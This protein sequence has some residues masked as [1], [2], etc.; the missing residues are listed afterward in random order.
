MAFSDYS[1]AFEYWVTRLG[2]SDN[3]VKRFKEMEESTLFT[4]GQ[5]VDGRLHR[6]GAV[7]CHQL[8]QNEDL[9]MI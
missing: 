9:L 4:G 5:A 2:L 7:R 1:D 3:V 6:I 8:S